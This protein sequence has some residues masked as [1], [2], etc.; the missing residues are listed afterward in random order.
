M[1]GFL[2]H[3]KFLFPQKTQVETVRI[4]CQYVTVMEESKVSVEGNGAKSKQDGNSWIPQ[5]L[6]W[7]EIKP[8]RLAKKKVVN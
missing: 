6:K 7:K 8:F 3:L 4:N 2:K 5:M 1:C